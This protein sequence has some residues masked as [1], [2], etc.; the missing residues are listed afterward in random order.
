MCLRSASFERDTCEQTVQAY[1]W[2]MALNCFRDVNKYRFQLPHVLM[3]LE[4][5]PQVVLI[6]QQLRANETF[7]K[8]L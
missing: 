1:L 6:R 5:N 7:C 3:R 2:R 4:V 8:Q